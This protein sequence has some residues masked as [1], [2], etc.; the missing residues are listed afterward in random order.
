[1]IKTL[2]FSW[3]AASLLSGELLANRQQDSTCTR[4]KLAAWWSWIRTP[5]LTRLLMLIILTM[6]LM[7]MTHESWW[8]SSWSRGSC[9]LRFLPQLLS[10]GLVGFNNPA[11]VVSDQDQDFPVKKSQWDQDQ[12]LFVKKLH[13]GQTK[14]FWSKFSQKFDALSDDWSNIQIYEAS[15]ACF[16]LLK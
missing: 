4:C 14:R 2:I 7:V 8:W 13:W 6:I 5:E 9:S 3:S 10:P 12:W 15:R 11:F 16:K 1:M